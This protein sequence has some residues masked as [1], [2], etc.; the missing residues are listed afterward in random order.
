MKNSL[1]GHYFRQVRKIVDLPIPAHA[2]RGLLSV[3]SRMLWEYLWS[4][5]LRGVEVKAF[6]LWGMKFE[7]TD[8]A[9]FRHLFEELF[10]S[11]IY[12]VPLS[13]QSPVILDCGSN[14]GMSIAFFKLAYP[15]SSITGFE[16]DPVN[17]RCLQANTRR[18][19]SDVIV[20]EKALSDRVGFTRLF[21][22]G[23][24][25]GSTTKTLFKDLLGN[26][27]SQTNEVSVV[28]LS[29]YIGGPVD[30]LKLDVEGA[31][32]L[33]LHDLL[34]SGKLSMIRTC[35]I[36]FHD[37]RRDPDHVLSSFLKNLEEQGFIYTLAAEP[38]LKNEYIDISA[39]QHVLIYATRK[40]HPA[41]APPQGV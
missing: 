24:G 8:F 39:I 6:S 32:T 16:P 17:F 18:H 26:A 9:V 22:A 37:I 2:R 3:Y 11:R 36:E 7:F 29:E 15:G 19:F 34:E 30:L 28:R 13:L 38:H 12:T 33:V 20:H 1:F 35:I 4:V 41:P 23:D 5:K 40:N 21:S 14:I 31:E 27:D 10:I 25:K